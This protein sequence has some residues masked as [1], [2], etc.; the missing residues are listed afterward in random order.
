MD[1]YGLLLQ[2]VTVNQ[3][4]ILL[5]AE[6]SKSISALFSVKFINCCKALIKI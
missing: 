2:A 6:Q 3:I 5:L 1:Q 4:T